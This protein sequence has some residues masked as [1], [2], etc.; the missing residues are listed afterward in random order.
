MTQV[1]ILDEA[2]GPVQRAS[3]VAI[4]PHQADGGLGRVG[5]EEVGEFGEERF[6]VGTRSAPCCE[7]G[8]N[9]GST[10]VMVDNV[11]VTCDCQNALEEGE[12]EALVHWG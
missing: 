6:R 8:Q 9:E 12:A 2:K 3:W 4:V 7:I 5:V 10:G 11:D 1:V